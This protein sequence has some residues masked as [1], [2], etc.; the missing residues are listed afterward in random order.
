[1]LDGTPRVVE[2]ADPTVT[3]V[4]ILSAGARVAVSVSGAAGAPLLLVH[5]INA[6]ASVAEVEPLRVAYAGKRRVF[7]VDLPG[8]GA[9]ERSDRVY[10]PQL[11]TTALVDV[12]RSIVD[13]GG[14]PLDALAVSLSSE[15]L[16]RAAAQHP[17][18]FRSLALV[19]PT[20]FN[21]TRSL[22]EPEGT[23]RGKAWL[24]RALRGPGW[25]RILYRGLTE[26]RVIR[27]F[28]R[29]TFGST[30]IDENLWRADIATSRVVGGEY[31]PLYFLGGFLFSTDI[32]TVYDAL[33]IP[34][35]VSHG[36]RGDFV[37]YR[38]LPS[39]ARRA[40]WPIS[41]LDTGALPYFEDLP[42]FIAEYDGFLD[43]LPASISPA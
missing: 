5:S 4:D 14:E 30:H 40:G 22:R 13:Q 31:A 19:S 1:M 29:R 10:I 24:Y 38:Q 12:A 41:V 42:R 32:H 23:T 9:S 20:G 21:G 43:A 16:A 2:V 26:P 39:F 35:W 25:G 28:L 36:R 7:C 8:F 17:S 27:Y 3:R 18:L 11:M 34:V 6:A 33:R 15:F 37:D